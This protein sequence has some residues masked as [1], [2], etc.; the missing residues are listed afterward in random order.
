MRFDAL[1]IC[2]FAKLV[3]EK[4]R[5]TTQFAAICSMQCYIVYLPDRN[6]AGAAAKVFYEQRLEIILQQQANCHYKRNNRSAAAIKMRRFVAYIVGNRAIST[7][8]RSRTALKAALLLE[9]GEIF[10]VL[11]EFTRRDGC[12]CKAE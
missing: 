11:I 7:V 2:I 6:A 8:V 1:G 12:C 5:R 3:Q 4:R 9:F 10:L